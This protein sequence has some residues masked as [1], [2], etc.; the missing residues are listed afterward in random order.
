MQQTVAAGTIEA[1]V[2]G[3]H[4]DPFAV[5]GVHDAGSAAVV[6]AFVPGAESV[7]VV[8]RDG[9]KLA[10]LAR[11]HDGG[12]FEG[13]IPS[14]AA[15]RLRATQ[16]DGNVDRR[17]SLCVRAGPRPPRRLADRRG[18]ARQALRRA[19][20]A[21]HRPRRSGRRAFR[22]L[23][24]ERPPRFRRR[25]FQPL[26][27]APHAMRKRVGT[28]VWE[29]FIPALREGTLYKYEI[30][31]A[32]GSLLPLKADPV[33]FG[34][35]LR[36]LTASIVR[37]TTRFAWTDADWMTARAA[38]DPR[39]TPMAIYE[40]HLGSW[41]RGERNRWLT[42]DE[43]ADTLVPYAAGHGVHA[44]RAH[45]RH[46]A[47][48]RRL[49]GLPAD[50]AVRADQPLRRACGVRALRRPLPSRR[51]RRDRR[52]GAGALSRRSARPR[53]GSTAPRSTSTPIRAWAFIPTGAR[54]SSTS[55]AARSRII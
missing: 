49:V 45:A 18:N 6:R 16:P 47:P 8:T 32:G 12:F 36:P 31:G 51:T 39:R 43:L 48:A 13:T 23:G 42:Y 29:I 19:G 11:R 50:R 53:A 30:V 38:R 20:C 10:S 26:G 17:R 15:Y 4:D 37:D 55:A 24:A 3:R 52:L 35:E 44:P 34:A 54:R 9:A 40:V 2:E 5:L 22:R 25:R 28:G 33:G 41:R 46:R 14:R 1:I 7:D 27:R 21:R